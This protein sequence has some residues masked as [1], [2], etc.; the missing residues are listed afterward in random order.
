MVNID[1]TNYKRAI[2]DIEVVSKSLISAEAFSLMPLGDYNAD[3]EKRVGLAEINEEKKERGIYE[4]DIKELT[5]EHSFC[6][7]KNATRGNTT[8]IY[9]IYDLWLEE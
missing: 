7:F 9:K 4:M 2:L 8:S 5:G 6:I 1:I 3:T